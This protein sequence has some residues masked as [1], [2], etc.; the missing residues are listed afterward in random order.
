ML[1]KCGSLN[2]ALLGL[3]KDGI[4]DKMYGRSLTF[5]GKFSLKHSETAISS[6]VAGK[7]EF[8]RG[9]L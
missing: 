7:F 2:A 9:N 6:G 5:A 3:E 1:E 8:Q 4:S